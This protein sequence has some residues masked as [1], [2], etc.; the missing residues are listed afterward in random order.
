LSS[1]WRAVT[2]RPSPALPWTSSSR[3]VMPLFDFVVNSNKTWSTSRLIVK[4][5]S[6]QF[7]S[8]SPPTFL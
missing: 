5:S 4:K 7:L 6:F 1:S 2:L 8:F 3:F